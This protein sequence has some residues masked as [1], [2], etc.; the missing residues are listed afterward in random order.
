[1][2]TTTRPLTI[3]SLFYGGFRRKPMK[4]TFQLY[5]ISIKGSFF[6]PVRSSVSMK[7]LWDK[8][9][10]D[11]VFHEILLIHLNGL[12]LNEKREI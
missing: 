4:Y 6:W 7:S 3:I 9:Q 5:E 11:V 12:T 8:A 2:Y 1:M 10:E